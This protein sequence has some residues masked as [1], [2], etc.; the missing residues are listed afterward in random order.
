MAGRRFR[1]RVI[2]LIETPRDVIKLKTIELVL[3]LADFS[4]I[5]SHLGIV[6]ARLLHDLVDD[7]LG[8]AS[9]VEVSDTEIDGDA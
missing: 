1:Q 5:Y 8:V 9:D 3:Q 6:A 7:Q 2:R 4:A